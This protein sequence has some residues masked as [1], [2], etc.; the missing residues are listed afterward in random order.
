MVRDR[1]K[2]SIIGMGIGMVTVTA[3]GLAAG[4]GL[5]PALSLSLVGLAFGG[6]LAERYVADDMEVVRDDRS[7]AGAA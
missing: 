4:I 1:T 6:W 5:F 2:V 3:L 7:D